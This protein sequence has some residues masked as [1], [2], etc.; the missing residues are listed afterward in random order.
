[1]I[2]Q[3][4]KII[5]PKKENNKNKKSCAAVNR[6]TFCVQYKKPLWEI[7]SSNEPAS[8]FKRSQ[9]CFEL[10]ALVIVKVDVIIN[11][12]PCI[13]KCFMRFHKRLCKALFC[14]ILL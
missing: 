9:F 12:P 14:G 7:K 10:N 5:R 13:G 8:Q 4:S 3:A 1:M 2:C 11:E 6:T